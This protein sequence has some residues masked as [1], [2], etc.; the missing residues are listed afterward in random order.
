MSSEYVAMKSF[1]TAATP[2]WLTAVFCICSLP[3]HPLQKAEL[4]QSPLP[5]L[6]PLKAALPHQLRAQGTQ[7]TAYAVQ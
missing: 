1:P 4:S 6:Q 5:P 3:R 2:S 7:A